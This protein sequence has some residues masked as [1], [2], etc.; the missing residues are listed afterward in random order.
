LEETTLADDREALLDITG[1]GH[2]GDETIVMDIEDTV[3]LV[4]RSKHG[5][6]NN[7]GRGV[8]D[9]AGL[10]MKLTGEEVNTE[11]TVLASLGRDGNTDHLARTS[12]ED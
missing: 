2:G 12:L 7:R 4:D 11:V 10:F 1:L 6:D 9:E 5:L 8:G 3:G